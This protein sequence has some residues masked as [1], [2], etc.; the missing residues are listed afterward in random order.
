MKLAKEYS[1]KRSLQGKA[2]LRAI[3]VVVIGLLASPSARSGATLSFTENVGQY[4]PAVKFRADAGGATLW[5]T[6]DGIYHHFLRVIDTAVQYPDTILQEPDS[7]EFEQYIIKSELVGANVGLTVT[8][9]TL[10]PHKN[11]YLIGNDP[12]AWKTDVYNYAQVRYSQVYQGVDLVV[13]SD[14]SQVEYDFVVTPGC[15]PAVIRM[16]YQNVNSVALNANGDLEI[17]TDFGTMI[18][19]KPIAFQ[20]GMDGS[21]INIVECEFDIL[22]GGEFGFRFPTG[23]DSSQTLVIDPVL[24]YSTYL[25]SWAD[26]GWAIDVDAEGNAY[27]TG[28]AGYTNFPT[29]NPFQPDQPSTDAFVTKFNSSGGALIYS[30][31]LGGSD[32]EFGTDIVVDQSGNAYISGSTSSTDFPT[33]NPMQPNFGGIGAVDAF[34]TK[35]NATGNGLIYSTYLGGSSYDRALGIAVDGS[36]RAYVCGSTISSDFPLQNPY[37]ADPPN[38]FNNLVFLSRLNAAGTA[39]EYSTYL[40][41]TN[42]DLANG[43]AVDA[44]GNAYVTG[45]TLSGDFPVLNPIQTNQRTRDAFVTK[46]DSTGSALV[47]STYLGG[48]SID[49][50]YAID[51]D[52]SGRAYVTGQTFSTD[53]PMQNAIQSVNAGNYDA[54][55]ARLNSAG[56]ALEYS[57]FLGGSNFESPR[58]NSIEVI[59]SGEVVVTGLTFSTN[60]PTLEPVQS[61]NAGDGDA[62]VTHINADGSAFVYSTYIGGAS[63]DWAWGVAADT[64][65]CV[66]VTGQTNSADFPTVDAYQ[67][68]LVGFYNAFVTKLC[69]GDPIPQLGSVTGAV[70]A[71]CPAAGTGL[72][73][74]G[75]DAFEIG[76]G[77]LVASAVTDDM[78]NYQLD[79]LPIGDYTITI[80]TPLGYNAAVDEIAITVTTS[81][82]ASANFALTC[83]EI[84]GDC[85]NGGFWKHQIGVNM[86]GVGNTQIDAAALCDYLDM[87]ADRFNGNQINAVVVYIPPVSGLCADKLLVAKE[88]LNLQGDVGMTARARQQLMVLLLNV[89][90]GN[91]SQTAI[92]SADGATLSQAITYCDNLIDDPSGDHETAK[93]I[94]DDINNNIQVAAGVIPLTTVNIAYKLLPGEYELMQNYP[95][96]FN[97]VTQISFVLSMEE[98]VKLEVFNLLGQVVATVHEG[99]LEAGLHSYIWDGSAFASGVYF[100]K[101]TAGDSFETKKM[102]LMK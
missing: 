16:V 23:Y 89:A 11:N 54:F 37:R 100:Y 58:F 60:F 3:A 5:I 92:V 45:Q 77:D 59:G 50:G 64:E 93:S 75:V 27:V 69:A 18:E 85:P 46:F 82:V 86:S 9:E 80:V 8:G 56:S 30:T 74:V 73:G 15:N 87:I 19:K 96:P 91:I 44:W 68:T 98:F 65:G 29:V 10:L 55:V 99:S 83:I 38:S 70:T 48:F 43:V 62:Y 63:R 14:S 35:L 24:V 67:P 102:V 79:S 36:G 76:T 47:Y 53:F 97:P 42:H 26:Q 17:E 7:L 22:S 101:L 51:V 12:A 95:N 66:Y 33:Q 49:I 90:A 57:T 84:I 31:Y 88:L 40:G 78:G 41:G 34:V 4:D 39:L 21:G 94:C 28:E 13:R 32:R 1:R 71:D 72:L 52:A 6:N 61:F 20:S 25:G 2:V 81:G